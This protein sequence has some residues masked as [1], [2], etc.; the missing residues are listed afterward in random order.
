MTDEVRSCALHRV[1]D[2]ETDSEALA[3]AVR[4]A[5]MRLPKS[6]IETGRAAGITQPELLPVW[7]SGVARYVIGRRAWCRI[8]GKV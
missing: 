5:E 6:A 1:R 3:V 2:Q 8:I 4:A 7:E